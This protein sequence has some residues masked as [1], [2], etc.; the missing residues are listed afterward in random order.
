MIEAIAREAVE[1]T[2]AVDWAEREAREA[3]EAVGRAVWTPTKV[4]WWTSS[5]VTEAGRGEGRLR[6]ERS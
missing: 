2:E 3:E 1:A 5:P 4:D 6:V